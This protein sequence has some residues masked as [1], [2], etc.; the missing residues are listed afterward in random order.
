M[1][2]YA[3]YFVTVMLGTGITMVRPVLDMFKR[4]V[5]AVLAVT[6]IVGGSILLKFT[7]EAMLGLSDPVPYEAY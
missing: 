7:L 1:A 2:R 5:S 6:G 3:R 4:P